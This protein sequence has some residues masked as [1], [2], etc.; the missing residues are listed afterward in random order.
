M[1]MEQND[2]LSAQNQGQTSRGEGY[3]YDGN[4]G[5]GAANGGYPHTRNTADSQRTLTEN[6]VR[7]VNGVKY[8]MGQVP[9]ASNF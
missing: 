3:A 4:G 8:D 6:N 1:Q 2:N 7:T 9:V 5:Y